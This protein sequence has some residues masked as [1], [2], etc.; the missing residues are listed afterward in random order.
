MFEEKDV[1]A[2]ART[3]VTSSKK[4]KETASGLVCF[5]CN[6]PNHLAKDCLLRRTSS[7][8]A[9]CRRSQGEIKCYRCGGPGHIA[10]SCLE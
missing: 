2:A 5:E 6:L 10:S 7:T 8:A 4:L 3:E 9:R 1:A